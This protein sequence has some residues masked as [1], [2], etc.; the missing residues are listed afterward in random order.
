LSRIL[1]TNVI[2]VAD[3]R[4]PGASPQCVDRSAAALVSA[5]HGVVLVDKGFDILTEYANNIASAW[6]LSPGARFVRELQNNLFNPLRC[7]QV[8]ITP[9]AGRE[10]EEFPAD[11]ALT[12]FDRGD[13]KFVAVRLASGETAR[14]YNSVDSDWWVSREALAV[15]AVDVEFLCL[16]HMPCG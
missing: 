5:S 11:P 14:I 1:D 15:H 13:R 9:H 12:G 10:Y 4:H 8:D 16:E 2:V 7:R 3:N 6:P